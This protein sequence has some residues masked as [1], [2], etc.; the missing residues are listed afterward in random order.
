MSA[1]IP[2]AP[3]YDGLTSDVPYEAFAD[4]YQLIFRKYKVQPELV[5][6]LACGTGTLTCILARRGYEMIGVDASQDMLAQAMEKALE[7]PEGTR[8]IFLCQEMEEL[9]LFGT[10]QAAVCSL[11][12]INYVPQSSLDQVF[13]RLELFV[14]PGGI[15]VF[16]I[17]TPE[18]LHAMDGQVFLDEREDVFCVWRAAYYQED[19]ACV[20]G[21]DLFSR[22]TNGLWS[23]V[24]R[25]T[26]SMPILWIR[27]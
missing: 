10:V 21:I 4:F 19:N 24:R 9:D 27:W 15:L 26:W 11:D 18:K 17:N 13:H 25:S 8:P 2:L 5:L 23:G 7:L 14:E 6:D 20:Y 3:V 1:Y 22:L 16:D 12:G